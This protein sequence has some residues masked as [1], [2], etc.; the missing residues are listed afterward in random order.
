MNVTSV[1]HREI[2]NVQ[3]NIGLE[4]TQHPVSQTQV[5][6]K[7]DMRRLMELITYNQFGMAEKLARIA[8]QIY[9]GMNLDYFG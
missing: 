4:I 9:A 6:S 5:M 8:S 1:D 3:S 7:E 2:H